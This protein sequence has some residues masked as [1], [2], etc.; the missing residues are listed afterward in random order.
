MQE[1]SCPRS[2]L[3]MLHRYVS[4]WPNVEWNPEPLSCSPALWFWKL[5]HDNQK[6]RKRPGRWR[7]LLSTLLTGHL[8]KMHNTLLWTIVSKF[9]NYHSEK[10]AQ[11]TENGHLTSP[12]W[13]W[14]VKNKRDSHCKIFTSKIQEQP[15]SSR[16]LHGVWVTFERTYC[17]SFNRIN[18]ISE[19]LKI[20]HLPKPST[21]GQ[22]ERILHRS[23]L[24][25]FKQ[26]ALILGRFL[27][28]H[29][30]LVPISVPHNGNV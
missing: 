21:F 1:G 3:F 19:T 25:Q 18:P 13:Q 8:K 29:E 28:E 11:N 12:S 24:G 2:T 6:N 30:G 5:K 4:N 10:T 27:E 7:G 16:I 9:P 14:H 17:F 20:W 15:P 22:Y 26:E 23:H